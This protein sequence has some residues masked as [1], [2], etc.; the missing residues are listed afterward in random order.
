MVECDPLLSTGVHG[1]TSLHWKGLSHTSPWINIQ[2][3]STQ[4][5]QCEVVCQYIILTSSLPLSAGDY[6]HSKYLVSVHDILSGMCMLLSNWFS[7]SNDVPHK[8]CC[9]WIPLRAHWIIIIE[10]SIEKTQG[11]EKEKSS[12]L[13]PR[14]SS[15]AGGGGGTAPLSP[16][17]EIYFVQRSIESRHF[18]SQSAP[19]PRSLPPCLPLI[20]KSLATPLPRPIRPM[21]RS[22]AV[23]SICFSMF[24]RPTASVFKSILTQ[25]QCTQ[26]LPF[27]RSNR[28]SKTKQKRKKKKINRQTNKKAKTKQKQKQK[29]KQNKN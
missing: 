23:F 4:S 24:Q 19:A 21:D 8:R 26:V 27:G 5:I 20:L 13:S 22:S 28:K 6:D 2:W 3:I 17:N 15:V 16:P 18:E 29:T 11:P 25:C 7:L 1:R 12:L 14:P 9:L 10:R